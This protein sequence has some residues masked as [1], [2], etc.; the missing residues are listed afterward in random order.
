MSIAPGKYAV[1]PDNAKLV[2]NTGRG[3][4]AAKAG[5]DLVIEVTK[6]SGTLELAEDP[7]DGSVT[8]SADGGSLRVLE[9]NGGIQALGDD[10]KESITETIDD[11]I[12]KSTK[13][14]FR[15]TAVDADPD[16]GQ[17]RVS[18]EL[19]LKGTKRPL[20]FELALTQDGHLTGVAIVKQSD[21][22]IKPYSTLF[23]TLK[24]T[25]EVKVTI[26]AKLAA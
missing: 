12:L 20:E 10:D 25:D 7:S 16:G 21:W 23:G 26:D 6:W 1:G 17:L 11:E 22:G 2:V 8:L 24:V 18:G 5:H 15:S 3:G 4:A 9:G 19:E 13:I 14:E